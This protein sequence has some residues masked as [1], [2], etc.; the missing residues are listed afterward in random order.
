VATIVICKWSGNHPRN[1]KFVQL[2]LLMN[3][4]IRYRLEISSKK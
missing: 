1:C 2:E 3:S 4:S